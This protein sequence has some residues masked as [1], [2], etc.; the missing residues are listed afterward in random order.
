M[1]LDIF[2]NSD[3]LGGENNQGFLYGRFNPP[4]RHHYALIEYVGEEFGLDE[5]VVGIVDSESTPRNPMS[6]EQVERSLDLSFEELDYDFELDTHVHELDG[7]DSLMWNDIDYVEDDALYYTGDLKHAVLTE[8]RNMYTGK[9]MDVVYE[10]RSR[11][12]FHQQQEQLPRSGTE[13]R[14]AIKSGQGWEELIPTGTEK[15]MYENPEIAE[16]ISQGSSSSLGKHLE[17]ILKQN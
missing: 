1:V 7:F 13:V 16:T 3:D 15:V 10:P 2:R 14:E 17:I 4:S 11:Q 5:V 12:K 9:D 8:L 6:A